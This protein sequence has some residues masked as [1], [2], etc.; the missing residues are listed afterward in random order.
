LAIV[1]RAIVQGSTCGKEK[2]FLFSPT[3]QCTHAST[4]SADRSADRACFGFEARLLFWA[5]T[6]TITITN[7]DAAVGDKID[8]DRNGTDLSSFDAGAL[9][10]GKI[11]GA[12]YVRARQFRGFNAILT[13]F[14]VG[15]H[16]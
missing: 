6:K 5:E 1:R 4:G 12:D 9:D 16:R 13:A 11:Y 3:P 15:I 10:V 2:R 7:V 8:N 14:S